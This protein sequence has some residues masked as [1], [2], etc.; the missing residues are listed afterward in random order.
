MNLLGIMLIAVGATVVSSQA[1]KNDMLSEEHNN[2]AL[3]NPELNRALISINVCTLNEEERIAA[4]LQSIVSQN[5]YRTYR[6]RFELI[7]IDSASTDRT[8]EVAKPYADY[9]VQAPKG[10]LRARELGFRLS[11]GNIIVNYDADVEVPPASMNMLLRPFANPNVV[12]V[13][14]PS[15]TQDSEWWYSVLEPI[16]YT[17]EG[18]VLGVQ[19]VVGRNSAFRKDAYFAMGG[20]NMN[21][22]QSKVSVMIDEEERRFASRLRQYGEVLYEGKACVFT[23]KHKSHFSLYRGQQNEA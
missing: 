5:I 9:I 6:D 21:I 23:T 18:T 16:G 1:L 20:F 17:L 13:T 3:F 4:A 15:V 14:G 22:D 10:K 2:I 19:R 8:V 7:V 11:R 12:A